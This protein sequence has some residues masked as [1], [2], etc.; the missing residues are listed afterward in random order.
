MEW[1]FRSFSQQVEASEFE[2]AYLCAADFKKHLMEVLNKR[3]K[4]NV[5][6]VMPLSE[7]NKEAKEKCYLEVRFD[8]IISIIL[9]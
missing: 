3:R 2:L 6:C 9:G 4:T 7:S 8:S 5:Q 1:T